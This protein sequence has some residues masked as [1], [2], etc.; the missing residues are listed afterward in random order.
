MEIINNMH[1]ILLIENP[2]NILHLTPPNHPES[3]DRLKSVLAAFNHIDPSRSHRRFPRKAEFEN[4]CLAHSPDYVNQLLSLNLKSGEQLMLDGDTCVS[5]G[6]ID[7]AL[8]GV[9]GILDL[10]DAIAID[11]YKRGFNGMRPPGHHAEKNQAMGFCF[12]GTAAIGAL[13]AQQK[14]DF[15]KIAI[16]DF[17]VHHGNGTQD[18]LWAQEDIKF[19]STHECPL[20]PGTG[21]SHEKGRFGQILNIPIEA[22]CDGHD[23]MAQFRSLVIPFLADTKPD[24]LIFSAGFDAHANDPLANINFEAS[25]FYTL[26]KEAMAAC[27]ES[28][29]GR[30]IS[31][32]EGGYNL[33]ALEESLI[34][35]LEAL[36]EK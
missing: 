3:P 23:Y 33:T 36:S 16:L 32:L 4:I 10:V 6:S 1:P 12:F 34:A 2:N 22:G 11:E 7:A 17:D 8:F 29:K 25:D 21:M 5:E 24:L 30:F 27:E 35:H 31:T 19:I 18:I 20:F 9:G 28:T 13:Y 26:T 14:Y 15:P